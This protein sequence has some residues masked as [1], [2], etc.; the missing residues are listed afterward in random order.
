MVDD[1][2]GSAALPAGTRFLKLVIVDPGCGAAAALPRPW[3]PVPSQQRLLF[4]P[5]NYSSHFNDFGTAE[6]SWPACPTLKVLTLHSPDLI[7][8]RVI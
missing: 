4:S 7:Q 5:V 1:I 3:A 8:E 6:T 2:A